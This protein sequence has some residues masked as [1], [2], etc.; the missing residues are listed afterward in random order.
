[1]LE[2]AACSLGEEYIFFIRAGFLFVECASV[3]ARCKLYLFVDVDK[4]QLICHGP[5]FY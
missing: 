1:M 3:S 5:Q 2:N 4:T